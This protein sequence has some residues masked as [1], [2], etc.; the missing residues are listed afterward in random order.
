M[1]RITLL[2]VPLAVAIFT[3]SA[4]AQQPQPTPAP[5]TADVWN[6]VTHG[7][8]DNDGVKLHYASLGSGPRVVMIHGYPD[9]WYT[10]RDQMSALSDRFRV[11]AIDQRG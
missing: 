7:T 2:L 1:K 10:W 6:S 11:V 5:T 8:V 4:L 3:L 9:F